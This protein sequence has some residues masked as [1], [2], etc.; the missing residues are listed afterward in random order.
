MGLGLGEIF[1]REFLFEL[2]IK[3]E[4][5]REFRWDKV[6]ANGLYRGEAIEFEFKCGC[7][8]TG[9]GIRLNKI[10]IDKKEFKIWRSYLY[11]CKQLELQIGQR[12][13][14]GYDKCKVSWHNNIELISTKRKKNSQ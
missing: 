5:K 9:D 2:E 1:E 4:L 11:I 12:H 3:F 8:C 14:K 7:C 13:L 10:L 6:G